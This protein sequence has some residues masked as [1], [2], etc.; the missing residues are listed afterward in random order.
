M[1][2]FPFSGL[3]S[4]SGLP[5]F[6]VRSFLRPYVSLGLHS[7]VGENKRT[8]NEEKGVEHEFT[9]AGQ[10]TQSFKKEWYHNTRIKLPKLP[11]SPRNLSLLRLRLIC[12]SPILF[13]HTTHFRHILYL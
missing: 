5:A 10:P 1:V 3:V 2:S 11:P 4:L 6:S 9:P 12:S 8:Q 7:A 13:I